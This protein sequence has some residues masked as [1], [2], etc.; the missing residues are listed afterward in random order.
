MSQL[1]VKKGVKKQKK[2]NK[3]QILNGRIDSLTMNIRNDLFH[4]QQVINRDSNLLFTIMD[5]LESAGIF[6]VEKV[7]T[8]TDIN[9]RNAILRDR[10]Y[11]HPE[12]QDAKAIEAAS[13]EKKTSIA[14]SL[15]TTMH[16]LDLNFSILRI[17]LHQLDILFKNNYEEI[18]GLASVEFEVLAKEKKDAEEK[19][20]AH[21]KE[22]EEIRV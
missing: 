6:T 11:K 5:L 7:N 2:P 13:I 15:A 8:E 12:L 19:A 10:L 14:K 17:K 16:Q 20:A 22:Q 4:M 21:K 1:P 3:W 18:I 9:S